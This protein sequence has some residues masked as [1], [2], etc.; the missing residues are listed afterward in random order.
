VKKKPTSLKEEEYR[1]KSQKIKMIL[2]E[3]TSKKEIKRNRIKPM[4]QKKPEEKKEE[5]KA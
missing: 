5:V 1:K 4:E 3:K 2:A